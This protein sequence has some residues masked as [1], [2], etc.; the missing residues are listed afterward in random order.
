MGKAIMR[1]HFLRSP[2]PLMYK[3]RPFKFIVMTQPRSKR[4]DNYVSLSLA[5]RTQ[6]KK[7]LHLM[8]RYWRENSTCKQ[9]TEHARRFTS[10]HSYARSFELRTMKVLL[11]FGLS[12]TT[13]V[14]QVGVPY[15]GT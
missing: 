11:L 14:L 8:F 6:L 5:E 7:L 12:V 13:Y 2:I 15:T 3:G 9:Y 10:T 1:Q 4:P